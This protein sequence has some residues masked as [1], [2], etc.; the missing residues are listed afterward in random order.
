MK[1]KNEISDYGV[2]NLNF[3][4]LYLPQTKDWKLTRFENKLTSYCSKWISLM[5]RAT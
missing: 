3:S 1:G 5:S 2:T 4:I